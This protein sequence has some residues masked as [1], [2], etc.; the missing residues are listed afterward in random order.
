MPGQAMGV[1]GGLTDAP[2]TSFEMPKM[3]QDVSEVVEKTISMTR[4]FLGVN[5]V[6]LGNINP[7][8]TSAIIAVQKSTAAPLE[9]QRLAYYQFVEDVCRVWVDLMCQNYGLRTTKV[10]RQVQDP[11]TGQMTEQD[12]LFEIDFNAIDYDSLKI[13]VDIGEASYWSEIMQTQT[14]DNLFAKGLIPDAS[15]YIKSIPDRYL[16][17]KKCPEWAMPYHKGYFDEDGGVVNFSYWMYWDDFWE[18]LEDLPRVE[19]EKE[20]EVAGE[21]PDDFF[22]FTV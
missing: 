18:M 22:E 19:K 13:R 21:I 3:D 1:V 6:V 10:T 11:Y 8:N 20:D 17:N 7:S 14:M 15:T 5:D 12:A 9:I 2:A 16:P 4:D